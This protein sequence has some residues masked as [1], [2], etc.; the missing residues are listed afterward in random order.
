MVS[1]AFGVGYRTGMR[2]LSR[3]GE[4]APPIVIAHRGASRCALE[5]SLEAFSLS[6]AD[7]A[8]MIEFDVRLSADGEPVVI[9]DA[10]TG[11]TARENLAVARWDAARL[12]KVRLRNGEPLPFLADVLD[13][14]RGT[15]PVNIEAK[16]TGGILAALRVMDEM[17]YG[18][19]VLLSSGLRNECL[20][21]REARSGIPCG[22][23]TGRPTASDIAF[24]RRHS[25]SSIHPDSRKLTV[26]RIRQVR[27]AGLPFLPY[28][29]DDEDDFFRLV[30]GG[31]DGVFSNRAEELRAAWRERFRGGE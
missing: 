14:I 13:L 28:T 31:A 25:L 26:L 23:V 5:N 8:D 1:R 12:R 3:G 17:R 9:H 19:E 7:R 24:C 18:G 16:T 11:R 29:V 10:R 6:L 22:L 4:D 2:N 27:E 30:E 20:A 15:V 21:A